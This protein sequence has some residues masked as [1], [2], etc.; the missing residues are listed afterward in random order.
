VPRT[1]RGDHF[2]IG[3]TFSNAGQL[4]VFNGNARNGLLAGPEGHPTGRR[5]II[6]W[7]SSGRDVPG[8]AFFYPQLGETN[9]R[10]IAG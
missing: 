4:I 2:G 6:G 3:G 8:G 1:R 9:A 5:G 10:E 7:S